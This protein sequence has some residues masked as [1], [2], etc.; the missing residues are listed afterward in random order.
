[1]KKHEIKLTDRSRCRLCASG[2]RSAAFST[3]LIESAAFLFEVYPVSTQESLELL[4]RGLE[5]IEYK[6]EDYKIQL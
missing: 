3:V 4:S 1:M 6:I 2:S 5:K